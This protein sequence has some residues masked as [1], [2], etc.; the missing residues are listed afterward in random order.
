MALSV[1]DTGT[2]MSDEVQSHLFE[3][4]FTTKEVGKGTGLGL[5]MVYGIVEQSGGRILFESSPGQGTTFTLYFPRLDAAPLADAAGAAQRPAGG[6]ETI[7]LVEDEEMVRD[8][9]HRILQE[10]GYQVVAARSGG[11]ALSLLEQRGGKVDLL[12]TD[13]VMP[14]MSGRNLALH[15]QA[16]WPGIRVLYMSGYAQESAHTLDDLSL[17][18]NYLQKPFPPSE[19]ARKVREALADA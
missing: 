8:L 5:S 13:M 3:P 4:F 14:L 9:A 16:N 17:K 12:L 7:L 6:H 1:N 2:G 10:R 15:V 19:L 11:E 18:N